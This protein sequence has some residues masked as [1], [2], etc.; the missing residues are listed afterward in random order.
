MTAS[1]RY[2]LD[3]REPHSHRLTVAIT[4]RPLRPLLRL[5]LPAW[6][7]GSYLER[8]YGRH[9]E[10]LGASQGGKRLELRRLDRHS[11]QLAVTPG[12]ELLISYGLIAVEAT[13]RTNWLDGNGGF[14][15]AAAWALQLE[16][17]RWEP[18]RLEL[19]LPQGWQV[20]TALTADGQGWLA[21]DYDELIDAP[22][23]LGAL[24][25]LAFAV[26]GVPHQWVWQGLP[27]P[28]PLDRWQQDLP[29][30]CAAACGLMGVERPAADNYLFM[31]RFCGEGYGGLEHNDCS[32]LIFSRRELASPAGYRRLLQLVAHEYL[33]QWNV[34]RLRPRELSPYS[35]GGAVIVPTLWFAEGVTSYFDSLVVYRAGLC[36]EAELLAEWAE[37]ITRYRNTPGRWVQSLRESSEEAWVKL[38]RRDAHSDNQ[39]VSYYLKGQLVAMLIDLQLRA[40]GGS[41]ELLLQ[42]LWR[43][44]GRG[45]RGYS[46]ED[47]IEAIGRWD[48]QLAQLCEAWLGSTGELPLDS[49]LQTV[50]LLLT[51]QANDNANTGLQLELVGR[52]LRVR[53]VERA[54]PA[55]L[56]GLAP[57][58]ELLALDGERLYSAEQLEQGLRPLGEHQLLFCRDGLVH[59]SVL[60]PTAPQPRQWQL[61]ADP[62]APAAPLLLRSQWLGTPQA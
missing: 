27:Q 51:A 12:E 61:I 15:T 49:Y 21:H 42:E 58:D 54:S 8:D 6:T 19:L 46:S 38:Y 30:L 32:A 25:S 11:W 40:A 44:F 36:S 24:Q 7:P 10:G 39:Q 4:H 33:H 9:L 52:E 13:V 3:L 28:A 16:G 43:Q 17:C 2:C 48:P 57:S 47:L 22:I 37:Q 35:Y 53:R 62:N 20:A 18:H 26:G 34:R 50:G 60:R 45:G 29:R 1:L 41:L 5:Q 59:T 14:L 31:T 23:S 56:G 55:E